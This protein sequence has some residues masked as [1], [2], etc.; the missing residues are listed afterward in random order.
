VENIYVVKTQLMQNT[1]V[2]ICTA[3]EYEMQGIQNHN[4]RVY[5]VI[6]VELYLRQLLL[7]TINNHV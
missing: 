1:E 4:V 7:S 5:K 2:D 3:L 6:A